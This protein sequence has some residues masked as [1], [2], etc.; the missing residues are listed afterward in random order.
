MDLNKLSISLWHHICTRVFGVVWEKYGFILWIGLPL[1]TQVN[2]HF[3]KI[4]IPEACE[5][6]HVYR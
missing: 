1:S 5:G 3:V 2:V 6:E 4:R